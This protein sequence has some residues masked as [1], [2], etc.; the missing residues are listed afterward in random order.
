MRPR[1]EAVP[2]GSGHRRRVA[3]L[4]VSTPVGPSGWFP[5]PTRRYEFR[6]HNGAQWTADVAVNGQRY[7]DPAGSPAWSPEW[8][9]AAPG[10]RSPGR[11][12]AVAAFVVGLVSLLGAWI[13]FVFVVAAVG[14]VVALAL[15]ITASRQMK[16]S[17][18]PGR[19]YAVT[20]IILGVGALLMC[21]PGALLT[22]AVLRE[23]AAFVEPGEHRVEI[24]RCATEQAPADS[25]PPNIQIVTPRLVTL[26]G[27][28]TNLE[29]DTRSYTITIEYTGSSGQ[30][31]LDTVNVRD[32]PAGDTVD[33]EA[34]AFVPTGDGVTCAITDVLGPL[35]FSDL[36][37][38]SAG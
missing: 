30:T 32:V 15:G 21:I 6:Y 1:L 3:S 2:R 17:G 37:P 22:R 11:G 9:A 33:F 8:A 4:G 7:V 34:N 38:P 28:I 36:R 5:D 14:A 35:P 12:K 25:L 19:G 31:D 23:V 13:P 16:R 27:T 24:T 10:G 20:G 18:A 29:S 26:Q